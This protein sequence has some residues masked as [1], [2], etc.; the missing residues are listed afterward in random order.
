MITRGILVAATTGAAL[1]AA[2]AHADAPVTHYVSDQAPSTLEFAFRQAGAE[3]KGKFTR[4]PV[5]LDFS[6]DNLAAGRLEVTV[7]MNSLDTGDKERDDTLRGAELFN[8]AK[9]PQAHF[10][11]TQIAKTADG[12]E[13]SGKLTIRDATRD[14]RVPFTFRPVTIAG[15]PAAWMLGKMTI[16]RLDYGVG[17][18]D[19]KATDQVGNEVV[20]TFTVRLSPVAQ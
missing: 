8:V 12:Y 16:K 18:G 11:A 5:K 13:A 19:W 20:V 7:D 15:K 10:L 3:N 6:P 2:T 1:F 4:F 9:F 14:A 17:Q